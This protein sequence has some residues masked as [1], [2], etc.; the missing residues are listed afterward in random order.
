MFYFA[1][2][3]LWYIMARVMNP[4][5]FLWPV[6]HRVCPVRLMSFFSLYQPAYRF[7]AAPEGEW[8]AWN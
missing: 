8:Q 2:F 4:L 1:E 5:R 7:Y 6:R 3:Y